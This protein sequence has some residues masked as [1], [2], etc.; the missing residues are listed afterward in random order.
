[1][2][3]GMLLILAVLMLC[4]SPVWAQKFELT[5]FY[6]YRWG[7]TL[8]SDAGEFVV[9]AS[10]NYG[11]MF[12]VAIKPGGYVEFMYSRQDGNVT[13]KHADGS[14]DTNPFDL[15]IEYWHVGCL[16]E[17]LN[18]GAFRPFVVIGLGATHFVPTGNR[19][20]D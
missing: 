16:H 5:P 20:S 7:G 10:G 15:A 1:M 3:R 11:I 9:D 14:P 18:D 2:R 6:G 8:K 4:S 19:D 13:L 12:D 17:F